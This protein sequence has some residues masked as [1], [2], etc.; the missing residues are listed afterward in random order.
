MSETLNERYVS[1]KEMAEI[2][3]I[4]LRQLDHLVAEGM[5]S[6]KWGMR[7]RVFLPSRAIRWAEKRDLSK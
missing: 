7:K 4:S 6:Q 2:L 3:N 1:R 5:P